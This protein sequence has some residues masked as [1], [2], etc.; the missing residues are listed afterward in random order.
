MRG[1]CQS[2][3]KG[4][5]PVPRK[6]TLAFRKRG[7][8]MAIGIAH[9]QT[10][11][12]LCFEVVP[13]VGPATNP[14]KI[15]T[16]ATPKNVPTKTASE[17]LR[18]VRSTTWNDS[19]SLLYDA[20]AKASMRLTLRASGIR[21]RHI[22]RSKIPISMMSAKNLSS[23][24]SK[25]PPN[26]S[27]EASVR[28]ASRILPA[29]PTDCTIVSTIEGPSEGRSFSALNT[30]NE[31]GANQKCEENIYGKYAQITPE[32][33]TAIEDRRQHRQ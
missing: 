6:K 23:K 25:L 27:I 17:N 8:A 3:C 7:R 15:W 14:K 29:L 11:S 26:V 1:G 21:R 24:M 20:S 33:H 28:A 5:A 2:P 18:S 32:Q 10:L 16:T 19:C 9:S 30:T 31:Q 13:S 4:P 22:V 12:L